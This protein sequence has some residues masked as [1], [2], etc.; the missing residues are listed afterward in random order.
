MEDVTCH[1]FWLYYGR[2]GGASTVRCLYRVLPSS[3][4]ATL[5]PKLDS[6]H[7]YMGSKPLLVRPNPPSFTHLLS[8]I[9]EV[10]L[11]QYWTLSNLPLF[12]LAAPMLT[13]L[14]FSGFWAWTYS[15]SPLMSRTEGASIGVNRNTPKTRFLEGRDATLE[16]PIME[17]QIIQLVVPQIVLAVL[18]LLSYHVQIITRLSSG[19]PVW[20]WWLAWSL[21][22]DQEVIILRKKVKPAVIIVRW[23]IAY[24]II[25]GGLFA[26]FLP[27]A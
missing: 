20:Y 1:F 13:I 27:P 5:V 9:R 22:E 21:Y 14:L 3:G 18:A 24:A 8:L 7:L 26:S 10:G 4:I 19:Y 16:A 6:E 11:F 15:F 23:M 25:Q 12:I 2:L 17:A